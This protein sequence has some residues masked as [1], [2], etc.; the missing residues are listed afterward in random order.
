MFE[1]T[2]EQSTVRNEVKPAVKVNSKLFKTKSTDLIPPFYLWSGLILLAIFTLAPFIYLFTSSISKTEE[3][4]SGHLI[5]HSPTLENYYKLFTGNG[6]GE[7]IAAMKNSVIVSLGTTMLTLFLAIF[8]SFAFS[9]VK[10]PFRNSAL[11][12]V[13]AM[14][15]LPSISIIAPLYVMM[16]NGIS[17]TIPFTSFILFQTPPLL[18]TV[19]A[20]IISY[21]TFSLP[22]AIWIMT[23][24]FQ[25][26][27]KALEEAAIIDGCSRIGTLFRIIVPL[28]MPGIAAT[29]IFTLLLAWDE[30]MFASA[31]TQTFA[32]K[33]LPIAIREFIG[34]HSIDWGLMTAGGF[35]ASLPPVLVSV[36]LYKYIVGGLAGGGVKE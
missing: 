27:P 4:L 33:T 1:P 19:W 32:S 16:R 6:A 17:I 26:I 12:T 5:P 18:D 25:T 36:F 9:K 2:L 34:K 15:L 20:L 21:T 29:A 22:F 23:G 31:F 10:F 11:F 30:F 35:I 13:L 28:A 24:Y 3:L 8:A 14:Q 7:F